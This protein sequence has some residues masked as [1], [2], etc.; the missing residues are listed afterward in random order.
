MYKASEK[1]PG[2]GRRA[3]AHD[4]NVPELKMLYQVSTA[5]ETQHA[6]EREEFEPTIIK[7]AIVDLRGARFELYELGDLKAQIER[8]TTRLL[9]GCTCCC[10]ICS[11]SEICSC[12]IPASPQEWQSQALSCN[13][14]Q[15]SKYV[16]MHSRWPMKILGLQRI[17]VQP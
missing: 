13:Q 16:Q 17:A 11:M 8:T 1:S 6:T 9:N 7:E 12:G 15:K 10:K 3:A 2:L 5:R 14:N 4:E